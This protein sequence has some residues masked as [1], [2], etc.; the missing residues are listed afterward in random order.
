M[1][2]L[3]ISLFSALNTVFPGFHAL[4]AFTHFCATVVELALLRPQF[5]I[6][7]VYYCHCDLIWNFLSL[8]CASISLFLPLHRGYGVRCSVVLHPCLV[9]IKERMIKYSIQV[10]PK[11][12]QDTWR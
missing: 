2:C 8:S 6:L 9:C 3:N 7:H 11:Y 12:N 5:D 10:F 4:A 1:Y